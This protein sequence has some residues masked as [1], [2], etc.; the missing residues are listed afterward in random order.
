MIKATSDKQANIRNWLLNAPARFTL[1]MTI[2][3]A[4]LVG[5]SYIPKLMTIPFIDSIVMAVFIVALFLSIRDLIKH[6]PH[7]DMYHTDFVAIINGYKITSLFVFGVW[8]WLAFLVSKNTNLVSDTTTISHEQ[9][10]FSVLIKPVWFILGS[11]LLGL[12]ISG[13]YAKYKRAQK[14]GFTPWKIIL[15]M[16]FCFMLTWM[17]GYLTADKKQ[18]SNITIK[19]KWYRKFNN[20]VL[21]SNSKMLFMFLTLFIFTNILFAQTFKLI[22]FTFILFLIYMFWKSIVKANFS[23]HMDS[24]YIWTGIMLNLSMLILFIR[25]ILPVIIMTFGQH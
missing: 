10:L 20:W 13:I 21:S 12:W 7:N 23:K 2:V 1:W 19:S 17:P 5:I 4:I 18:Q 22:I 24:S 3:G 15:T 9:L 11:Y 8:L 25:G 14:I 16:P 6:L